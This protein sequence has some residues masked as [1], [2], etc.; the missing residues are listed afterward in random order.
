MNEK[1]FKNFRGKKQYVLNFFFDDL[2]TGAD[3]IT[4]GNQRFSARQKTI[5]NAI[6][7]T[8]I[9]CQTIGYEGVRPCYITTKRLN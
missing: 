2:R 8:P 4:Q 1:G 3:L 7:K 5:Y 6:R 9:S